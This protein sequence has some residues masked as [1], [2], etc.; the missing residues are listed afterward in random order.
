MYTSNNGVERPS[1]A[2]EDDNDRPENTPTAVRLRNSA[3]SG[4]V[5]Y[6]THYSRHRQL[7]DATVH[8]ANSAVTIAAT[9]FVAVTV[10]TTASS[11]LSTIAGTN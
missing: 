8:I 10:L 5:L 11:E 9:A 4:A 1:S 6:S 3:A 2:G 7:A